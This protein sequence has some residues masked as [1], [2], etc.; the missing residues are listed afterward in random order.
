MKTFKKIILASTILVSTISFCRLS[1]PK[2]AASGLNTDESLGIFRDLSKEEVKSYYSSLT[3]GISGNDLLSSLQ[4]ILKNNQVKL[5]YESGSTKSSNWDGY[6]LLD[7][8]W[9]KSPLTKEEITNQKYNTSD[10]WMDI[11]YSSYSIKVSKI[12]SGTFEWE[13]NGQIKSKQYNNGSVQFDREH[14]FPKSYG[15][16]GNNDSSRYKNLTAGCDMQNLHAAEHVGNNLHNNL[17][18]GDVVN[19]KEDVVSGI[20]GEIVGYVG[21]NKDSIE[22]FEPLAEDKG[23]IAR[24]IFYMCARYHTYEELGNNDNTPALTIIN[25]PNRASTT[26]PE[27]TKDNPGAYGILDDLLRWNEEDPVS[28]QEIHRNN[29]CHNVIQG[30]RNPF[31]DYPA[32][33]NVA[34][35]EAS[36]GIDLSSEDGVMSSNRLIITSSL[37]EIYKNN[38]Y[39]VTNLTIKFDENVISLSDLSINVT[40]PSQ[41][42]ENNV[43]LASY[44]FNEVGTYKIEFSYYDEESKAFYRKNLNLN[45]K[46]R[47]SLVLD[48]SNINLKVDAFKAFSLDGLI[49]KRTYLEESQSTLNSNDYRVE[50]YDE[51][52]NLLEFSDK[53]KINKPGDYTVKIIHSVDGDEIE[54]SFEIVVGIPKIVIII[55]AI[56]VIVIVIVFI[57]L[58]IVINK[59]NK[60]KKRSKKSS[61][62]KRRTSQSKTNK[63]K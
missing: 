7:R 52:M 30:N 49:V 37:N 53:Y 4:P 25:T 51:E 56:A 40:T 61:G 19:K 59:N 14:V 50:I 2:V 54:A 28:F 27:D 60:K 8:D 15:F 55:A 58:L 29:L 42:K 35:G 62:S 10:V 3:P 46:S 13:E 22:V 33:A 23:D 47:Y 36:D 45:V 11:M 24:T 5:K 41:T 6:Y 39:D 16:N 38:I 44:Q 34:F 18:Y 21:T 57:I 20:T 48:T 43:E 31:I 26:D 1:C 63:R 9:E 32:W 12:N 17:P